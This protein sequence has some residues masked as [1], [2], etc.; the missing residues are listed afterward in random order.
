MENFAEKG[1]KAIK[2]SL[3]ETSR[4]LPEFSLSTLE[5]ELLEESGTGAYG[6]SHCYIGGQLWELQC[7]GQWRV[8]CLS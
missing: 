5:Q 7:L 4:I 3:Q 1:N 8:T 6:I 2:F